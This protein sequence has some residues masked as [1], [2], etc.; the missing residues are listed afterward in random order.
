MPE[1]ARR[2]RKSDSTDQDFKEIARASL[3]LLATL[4]LQ[5]VLK[6]AVVAAA[7]LVPRA[8]RSFL[9]LYDPARD[10]L[11]VGASWGSPSPTWESLH[12]WKETIWGKV[13][14]ERRGVIVGDTR[15][16]VPGEAQDLAGIRSM[17]I[18]PLLAGERVIGV[19]SLEATKPRA[20]RKRDREL[21]EML[22]AYISAAVENARLFSQV[23][24]AKREWE[25]TFDATSDLI[26]LVD[27]EGRIIRVNKA[28]AA[29]LD[30]TPREVVGLPLQHVLAEEG[31]PFPDPFLALQIG[32]PGSAEVPIPRLG[33]TFMVSAAPLVHPHGARYGTV[34]V[35]T[36]ITALKQREEELRTFAQAITS[37]GECVVIT[38]LDGRIT[39]VNRAAEE[40]WGYP[41]EEL[42]G[43]PW[44][45]LIAPDQRDAF[46]QAVAATL[47]GGWR[48]EV[49]EVRRSGETFP[50]LLT[51]SL[52]RDEEG[53]PKAFIGVFRDVAKERQLQQQLLQSDKLAAIG[54]LISGVAHEL[55]NPLTV[56]MGFSQLL[57]RDE[58]IPPS[59]RADV[60]KIY[61]E[62][63]RARR[64]V[65]NLLTFARSH[66]PQ[67]SPISIN[68]VLERTLELRL[69]EMAVHNISVHKDLDPALPLM[70]G[71]FYQLQQVFLNIINNAVEAMVGSGKGGGSLAITTRRMGNTLRVTISDTGPG[72]PPE[73]MGRIFDPFFTTKEKGTGLG[74][75]I[76]YGIIQEHGGTIS[77]EPRREGGVTFIVDLPAMEEGWKE[78]EEE[79]QLLPP[80]AR[81]RI[82]VIDDEAPILDLLQTALSREGFQVEVAQK[83]E[84][85]LEKLAQGSYD[86]IISDLRM[87][88][89][90]G[91]TLHKVLQS[92]WPHLLNRVLF[93][94]GDVA[95]PGV[96]EF[97]RE[98]RAPY[99]VKPF[100][101]DE[102]R[103]A[104][105][106]LLA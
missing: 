21:L 31:S 32:G 35:A 87:P 29:R 88:H 69:Y 16:E 7:Q 25:R 17:V 83:G 22:A 103:S 98:V 13:F 62:A 15:S 55:N 57:L 50:A 8:D 48:G 101:I 93:L 106:K 30:R 2:Q 19:L 72:I 64:I 27:L 94:T 56:V 77:V 68:E 71:D 91:A 43:Q 58:T 100:T 76:S 5:E 51:T 40:V 36:E 44:E 82:L 47:K 66:K 53:R 49:R 99:L 90:D 38:D 45:L 42:L 67:R 33:G 20:F 18:V 52:V 46:Q 14:S 65:Q 26:A 78:A 104:I 80:P 24:Q 11:R 41:P 37:I 59:V 60:E 84:E 1:P 23:E 28:F 96:Q 3:S 97:F 63:D 92:R 95:S 6:R 81:R 39:F 34:L 85:A 74:L 79:S 75:S 9:F 10:D 73:H 105:S 86:L 70:M 102:V 61:K 89:M 54:Q 4:D 12:L